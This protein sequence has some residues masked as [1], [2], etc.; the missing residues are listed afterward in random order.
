M[1]NCSKIKNFKSTYI[2]GTDINLSLLLH[3]IKHDVKNATVNVVFPRVC[4]CCRNWHE[5]RS[6]EARM[7]LG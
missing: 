6:T 1:I 3:S 4:D 7:K 5:G 2:C